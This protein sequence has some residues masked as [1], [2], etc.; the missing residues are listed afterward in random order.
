MLVRSRPP[1]QIYSSERNA[2]ARR[3]S[4]F[5]ERYLPWIRHALI[6]ASLIKDLVCAQPAAA[7]SPSLTQPTR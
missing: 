3:A 7:T 1:A 6:G 2:W 5:E 4:L